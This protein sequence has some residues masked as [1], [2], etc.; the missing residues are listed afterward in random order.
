[1]IRRLLVGAVALAAFA[2]LG[3]LAPAPQP[4]QASPANQE[5]SL[6][7]ANHVTSSG[8]VIGEAVDFSGGS[9]DIWAIVDAGGYGGSKLTYR[10][11]LNGWDYR[12]GSLGCCKGSGDS[13]L[14][15]RL[16]NLPGGAYTMYVYDGDKEIARGGFGVRGSRG[17]DN[18]NDHHSD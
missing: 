9:N 11:T 4:V 8:E 15:F 16:H 10:L 3:P 5:V 18:D 1:M 7:F 17:S 13:S 2:S 6:Y 14:A 12:W